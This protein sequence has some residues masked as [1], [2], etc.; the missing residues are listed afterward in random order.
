M[1]DSV[2]VL[3]ECLRHVHFM[4][5]VELISTL[6]ILKLLVCFAYVTLENVSLI[7]LND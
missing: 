2:H 1:T 4:Y 3:C 6:D 7:N 5:R